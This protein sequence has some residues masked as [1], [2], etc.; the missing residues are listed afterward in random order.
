MKKLLAT[1]LISTAVFNSVAPI[2]P[3]FAIEINQTSES[4]INPLVLKFL[5]KVQ[6]TLVLDKNYHATNLTEEATDSQVQELYAEA[7]HLIVNYSNSFS[8]K[9]QQIVYQLSDE[10]LKAMKNELKKPSNQSYE[11]EKIN[12][13]DQQIDELFVDVSHQSLRETVNEDKLIELFK[14]FIEYEHERRERDQTTINNITNLF[15]R[16]NHAILIWTNELENKIDKLFIDSDHL[17]NDISREDINILANNVENLNKFDL[18]LN[19]INKLKSKI[20]KAQDLFNHS[21]KEESATQT[22]NLGGQGIGGYSDH[23]HDSGFSRV[24][25]EVKDHKA[26]L[27]KHSDY[28]FHW[29]GWK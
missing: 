10:L 7:T 6:K 11:I 5:N 25:L 28:Q 17:E 27:V 4:Q 19:C 9:E 29:G 24:S 15:E 20:Q 8:K 3:T 12:F 22:F 23:S 21:Q 26:S 14:G 16:L 13:Y 18:N 1:L 2:I